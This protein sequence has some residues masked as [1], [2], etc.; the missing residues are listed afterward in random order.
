MKK[1]LLCLVFFF[2]SIFPQILRAETIDISGINDIIVWEKNIDG[3][4]DNEA[5]RIELEF[6]DKGGQIVYPSNG[7]Y[8]NIEC[9]IHL[10]DKRQKGKL[11]VR[12]KG[13]EEYDEYSG[14]FGFFVNLENVE[15]DDEVVDLFIYTKAVL[16]DGRTLEALHP[17]NFRRIP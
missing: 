8:I 11:V 3:D 12:K 9:A 5:A 14:R 1:M 4:I 6:V 16:S 7:D 15:S 13:R 17:E 10:R 2:I